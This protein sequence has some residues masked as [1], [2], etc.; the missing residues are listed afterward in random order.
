MAQRG[1]GARVKWM[2]KV[3]MDVDLMVPQRRA[4]TQPRQM[5]NPCDLLMFVLEIIFVDRK[6]LTD[7]RIKV[8][9]EGLDDVVEIAKRARQSR[10]RRT[11]EDR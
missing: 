1:N 2:G 4:F 8:G 11:F 3:M 7:V 5:L 10:L 6:Q 9:S